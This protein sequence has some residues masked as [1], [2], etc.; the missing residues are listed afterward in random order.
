MRIARRTAP[1]DLASGSFGASVWSESLWE[2]RSSPQP[3]GG[4]GQAGSLIDA[5]RLG[6]RCARTTQAMEIARSVGHR[7][8]VRNDQPLARSIWR[9]SPESDRLAARINSNAF[10]IKARFLF[11]SHHGP[12]DDRPVAIGCFAA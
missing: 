1:A 10:S 12:A 4:G 5:R 3:A 6:G 7:L 2:R 9:S 8:L 11:G